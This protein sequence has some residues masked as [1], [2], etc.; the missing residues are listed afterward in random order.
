M[1]K[2]SIVNLNNFTWQLNVSLMGATFAVFSLIYNQYY[3]YYGLITFAFGIVTHTTYLFNEWLFLKNGT[4]SK[5]YWFAH[6]CNFV[7]FLVWILV[8]VKIY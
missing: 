3:I 8:L 7:L 5:Y 6:V 2:F 1:D 4:N